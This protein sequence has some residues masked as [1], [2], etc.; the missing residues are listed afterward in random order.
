MSLQNSNWFAVYCQN[1]AANVLNKEGQ[2]RFT[3]ADLK[4][5]L[6]AALEHRAECIVPTILKLHDQI[7]GLCCQRVGEENLSECDEYALLLTLLNI[8]AAWFMLNG[9]W[10]DEPQPKEDEY[11]FEIF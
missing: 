4:D 9:K 1:A 6:N 3:L 7:V 5:S 11:G 2:D 10:K 8:H